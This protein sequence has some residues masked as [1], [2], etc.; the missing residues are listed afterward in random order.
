MYSLTLL[1][2]R[3][4]F[5]YPVFVNGVD[6]KGRRREETRSDI[7]LAFLRRRCFFPGGSQGLFGPFVFSFL[8]SRRTFVFI[9][10]SEAQS[11]DLLWT[12]S[13]L[14]G[15]QFVLWKRC[16]DAL[17]PSARP[18]H[19]TPAPPPL[20][21]NLNLTMW[22]VLTLQ[23]QRDTCTSC[24]PNM[25]SCSLRDGDRPVALC[26]ALLILALTPPPSVTFPLKTPCAQ[27]KKS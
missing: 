26:T 15:C 7:V 18:L 23:P 25:Q 16:R 21:H 11:T 10:K 2:P 14:C 24:Q 6:E 4:V 20:H 12:Q 19:L 3:L 17:C 1:R 8:F 5:I 9:P 13:G 22:N 27:I